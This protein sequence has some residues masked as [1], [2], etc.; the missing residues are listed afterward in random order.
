MT[1]YSRMIAVTN[2]SYFAGQAEPEQAFLSA[3]GQVLKKKPRALILREKDMDEDSYAELA[4]KILS[5]FPES[6]LILHSFPRAA[7]SLGVKRLHLPLPLLKKLRAEDGELL[8]SFSLLGCSVHS[9]EEARF[10]FFCGAGYCIAG[11]I[12]ETGCKPGKAGMGLDFLRSIAE[13]VPIPV[14]GIGGVNE[15][16]L[17]QLLSAGAAGGCMMSGFFGAEKLC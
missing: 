9:A 6:P 15:K 3:L 1:D 12:F 10:A 13:A 5:L 16:N 4:G 8:Q 7:R 14:Y 2:R 11:N 17:P